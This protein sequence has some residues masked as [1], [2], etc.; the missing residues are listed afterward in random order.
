M[1]DEIQLAAYMRDFYY[2]LF[3][4]MIENE[5][6]KWEALQMFQ[7]YWN[8]TLIATDSFQRSKRIIEAVK[9]IGYLL[10]G[11]YAEQRLI[12]CARKE[13]DNLYEAL[14][15]LYLCGEDGTNIRIG[16]EIFEKKMQNMIKRIKGTYTDRDGFSGFRCA[17]LLLFFMFPEKYYFYKYREYIA[18]RE[19]IDYQEDDQIGFF[20]NCQR[21]SDEVRGWLLKDEQFESRFAGIN[22]KYGNID[23]EYHLAIQDLLWSTRY[24]KCYCNKRFPPDIPLKPIIEFFDNPNYKK[25]SYRKNKSS[26]VDYQL[27]A[28]KGR[29]LGHAGEEFVMDVERENLE[30]WFPDDP[31]KRPFHYSKEVGDGAGYDIVSYNKQGQKIYIEVKTTAGKYEEPFFVTDVEAETSEIKKQSYYLYRVY[32]FKY[33]KGA[34]GITKGS[35]KPFCQYALVYKVILKNKKI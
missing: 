8:L 27:M 21:M 9:S 5:K 10:N 31:S 22:K 20:L 3:P 12:E 34:I 32:R 13:P 19:I 17:S 30:L 23:P 2:Q 1:F 4:Y 7:S 18:I 33:G 35:L 6:F 24:Y 26:K 29:L 16:L 15:D 11:I 28:L 25:Q 14:H